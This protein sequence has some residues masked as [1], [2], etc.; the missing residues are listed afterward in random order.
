MGILI[1]QV[2]DDLKKSFDAGKM[3]ETSPSAENLYEQL[4][5][6]TR[7]LLV[8]KGLEATSEAEVFDLFGDHFIATGIVSDTYLDLMRIAKRG[9]EDKGI[10]EPHGEAIRS[11]CDRIFR[12]YEEMDDRLHFPAEA[13]NGTPRPDGIETSRAGSADVSVDYRGIP[14]P[15]NYVRSKLTLEE[16]S[17]GKT[18]E[19]LLDDGEPIENLPDSLSA[20]G[21]EVVSRIRDNGYWRV[22]VVKRV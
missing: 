2:E 9:V 8:I 15:M 7:S 1:N 11:F 16:M 4:Y 19:I 17:E 6:A 10:L 20:D 5:Y 12:L 22:V 14:C 13:T 3:C 18:L 21:Q